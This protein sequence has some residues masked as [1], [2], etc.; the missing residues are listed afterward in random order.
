MSDEPVTLEFFARQQQ[1]LIEEM[2][3]GFRSM[4][5]EMGSFRDDCRC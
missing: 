1:R 3:T 2:R 4:R 5:E